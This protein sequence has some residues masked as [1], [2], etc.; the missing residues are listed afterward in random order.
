MANESVLGPAS[1]RRQ[2]STSVSENDGSI[3][4]PPRKKAK[5]DS[6]VDSSKLRSSYASPITQFCPWSFFLE[7]GTFPPPDNYSALDSSSPFS[8]TLHDLSGGARVWSQRGDKER[9][10][11]EIHEDSEEEQSNAEEV[12]SATYDPSYGDDNKENEAS[13]RG[14]EDP[15]QQFN[16]ARRILGELV[17]YSEPRMYVRHTV[18]PVYRSQAV[19]V[20]ERDLPHLPEGSP[21]FEG[22]FTPTSG[23][24]LGDIEPTVELPSEGAWAD[25]CDDHTDAEF[26]EEDSYVEPLN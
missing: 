13:E 8:S 15:T 12:A 3:H 26:V 24:I 25:E 21:I 10:H 2:P 22:L 23:S 11:F 4:L 19:Q 20:N 9:Q 5:R 6:D 17:D 14:E 16:L 18:A 7:H 1:G